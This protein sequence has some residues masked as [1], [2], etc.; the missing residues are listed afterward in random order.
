VSGEQEGTEQPVAGAGGELSFIDVHSLTLDAAPERAWEAVAQVM[1]GWAGGAPP[2]LSA[3]VGALVAR[4][5]GCAD[6]EPP[7]PGP[8]LPEGM[9]GFHVAKVERPSLIALAGEH[10]FSRYALTFHIEHADGSRCVVKAETRAAFPGLAGCL[11]KR[12]VIGTGAHVIVVRRLLSSIKRR[13][14]RS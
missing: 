9:V 3:R 13:A 7:H 8:G 1:R 4:L 6:V 5:L 11:Y 2:R 10:R 12:A 14:E